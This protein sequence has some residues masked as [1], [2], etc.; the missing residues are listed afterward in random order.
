MRPI[1]LLMLALTSSCSGASAASRPAAPASAPVTVPACT[2]CQA[3]PTAASAAPSPAAT[4]PPAAA[5]YPPLSGEQ[6]RLLL[7]GVELELGDVRAERD[8]A[9]EGLKLSRAFADRLQAE[10][11][12]ARAVQWAVGAGGVVLTV[13]TAVVVALIVRHAVVTP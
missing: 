5:T 9:R 13:A 7:A 12:T 2:S 4:T 11:S 3:P 1:L 10:L 6:V 8:V